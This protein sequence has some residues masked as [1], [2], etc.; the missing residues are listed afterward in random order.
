MYGASD[1]S[2]L[3][4]CW[5]LPPISIS[6][7]SVIGECSTSTVTLC[8]RWPSSNAAKLLRRRFGMKN[9]FTSCTETFQADGP[10]PRIECDFRGALLGLRSVEHCLAG[11]IR[12]C[13]LSRGCCGDRPQSANRH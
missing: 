9:P 8:W 6:T 7:A 2:V 5:E 4:N 3:F 10:R 12:D 11:P 1:A 13:D